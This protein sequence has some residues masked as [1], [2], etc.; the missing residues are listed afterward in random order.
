MAFSLSNWFK[1]KPEGESE[2]VDFQTPP[3]HAEEASPNNSPP[4][5]VRTV[6]PTAGASQ[7]QRPVKP[8]RSFRP[9]GPFAA[10]GQAAHYHQGPCDH[11][12]YAQCRYGPMVPPP[13]AVPTESVS[14]AFKPTA[15]DVTVNL[16]IGDFLDRLPPSFLKE[17]SFDRHQKVAFEASE[18]YSDLAKGR[19][20]V[21]A[22]VIYRRC[23]EVFSRPVSDTED[24]EVPL[25]LQKL[26]SRWVMALSTRTDQVEEEN[27]G[28][29]ETPFL[30]VAMEDNARVP[31][32]AGSTSGAFRPLAGVS[33]N[34]AFRSDHTSP[35]ETD[36]EAM[37]V[38]PSR[39]GTPFRRFRRSSWPLKFRRFR[40][41]RR[42]QR[43]LARS[44]LANDHPRPCARLLPAARFV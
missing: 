4:A 23:P 30:Q 39:T 31:T 5:S 17:G 3:E 25:P 11:A 13:P 18:L 2:S 8:A 32:A 6:T 38:R 22:S 15:P 26:S 14:P 16:E 7:V 37:P 29:I 36:E 28:E 20:S 35:A 27:V 21:P 24:V 33:A 43:P 34:G 19:A 9:P 40:L 1:G 12:V 44:L 42:R 10:H 41:R